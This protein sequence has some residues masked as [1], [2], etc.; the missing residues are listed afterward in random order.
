MTM[1][2][3]HIGWD[4]RQ[5]LSFHVFRHSLERHSS[6]ALHIRPLMQKPL[7][8][9]GLYTRPHVERNGQSWDVIS[10]APMSTEF[11][12]TRFLIPHL[13]GSGWCMFGE[14]D[15]LALADIAELFSLADDRYAIMCV[16]HHYSAASTQ[17]MDGQR[18]VAY[19]RKNWSSLM[20]IN[21]DHPGHKRLTVEMVN[22]LPGRDLHRFCW[23]EDD[24]TGALPVEWNYLVGESM[25][26]VAPKIMHY[27]AGT[28]ETT[29]HEWLKEVLRMR[30][31]P[32][33]Y[34]AGNIA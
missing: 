32:E 26:K 2:D 9:E 8:H 5:P 25:P 30:Q 23:L 21:A 4:S 13:Q 28:A 29:A 22:T 7:R 6:V 34:R 19:P 14:C 33:V 10:G 3:L 12:I 17:K 31:Q 1:L 18:Q 11:A 27:T 20:L 15:M 16:K 24:E